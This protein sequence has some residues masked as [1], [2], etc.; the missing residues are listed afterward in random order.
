MSLREKGYVPGKDVI[1]EYRAAVESQYVFQVWRPSLFK[2]ML[3]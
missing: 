1:I 2:P 3:T